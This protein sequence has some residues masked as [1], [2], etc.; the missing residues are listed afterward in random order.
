MFDLT[1]FIPLS[2]K[3]E[4]EERFCP[5]LFTK[6]GK[7]HTLSLRALKRRCARWLKKD[8]GLSVSLRRY[9]IALN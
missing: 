7:L 9:Y 5:T 4:G 6:L 2:L 3:G 1:P 8:L